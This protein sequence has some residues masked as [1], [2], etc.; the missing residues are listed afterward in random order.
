MKIN[1]L[2]QR[3]D[4]SLVVSRVGDVLTVNG[5]SF[6]FANI[7]EGDTLPASAIASEWF[8]GPVD[9]VNSEL[10]LT[11]MLPLPANYSPEQAFPVP[12]IIVQDGDIQLPQ[13]LPP[14]IEAAV[15]QEVSK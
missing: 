5:E 15:L 2:S 10:E 7:K 6:D 14:V 1:L 12:L 11:L 9:R 8:V 3:S 4:E 13:P